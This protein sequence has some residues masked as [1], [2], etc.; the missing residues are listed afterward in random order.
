M[1]T[2]V[3]CAQLCA[4]MSRTGWP[5]IR[6]F[7]GDFGRSL[8]EMSLF[9]SFCADTKWPRPKDPKTRR[10]SPRARGR[11]RWWKF[12]SVAR[13]GTSALAGGRVLLPGQDAST[14]NPV[15][16]P[17]CVYPTWDSGRFSAF[18][19]AS[20]N[21]SVGSIAVS[22]AFLGQR[23][24]HGDRVNRFEIPVLP[25]LA[26]HMHDAPRGLGWL[27][28]RRRE[29]QHRLC[30]GRGCTVVCHWWSRRS[31]RRAA[32]GYGCEGAPGYVDC[33][34]L[35]P[36]LWRVGHWILMRGS[37][38]RGHY[39]RSLFPCFQKGGRPCFCGPPALPWTC[40][41]SHEA[42]TVRS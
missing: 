40:L 34:T 14:H 5:S 22:L 3:A 12:R 32:P 23:Y 20:S 17:C 11:R 29:A 28:R 30:H 16:G 10:V 36:V 19:R 4:T 9:V 41:G 24:D 42:E 8:S 37:F 18:A 26:A 7:V 31:V 13:N 35:W 6:K 33:S 38:G 1:T 15:C 21:A 2:G 39:Y 27:R 25:W